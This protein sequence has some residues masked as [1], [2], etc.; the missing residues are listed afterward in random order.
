M[1]TATAAG[2]RFPNV[3]SRVILHSGTDYRPV[4]GFSL[5]SGGAKRL[6]PVGLMLFSV[7]E[8]G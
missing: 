1:S 6:P 4:A 5:P 2:M 8:R 7:Y 3:I